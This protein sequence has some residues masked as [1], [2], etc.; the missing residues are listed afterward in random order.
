MFDIK[1]DILKDNP[2][3][4]TKYEKINRVDLMYAV[5]NGCFTAA[6]WIQRRFFIPPP[7]NIDKEEIF[8]N[9]NGKQWIIDN[10]MYTIADVFNFDLDPKFIMRWIEYDNQNKTKI[11]LKRYLKDVN[12]IPPRHTDF[13]IKNFSVQ[14]LP[15]V[16]YKNCSEEDFIKFL[17]ANF[18]C[19][20]VEWI[21]PEWNNVWE[22]IDNQNEFEKILQSQ[23]PKTIK[24]ICYKKH[25]TEDQL[26]TLFLRCNICYKDQ[27]SDGSNE[28]KMMKVFNKI[29]DDNYYDQYKNSIFTTSISRRRKKAGYGYDVFLMKKYG[30]PVNKDLTDCCDTLYLINHCLDNK[31][32]LKTAG[33]LLFF[34][35]CN[36]DDGYEG[37]ELIKDKFKF[38]DKIKFTIVDRDL[39]KT[40]KLL[41]NI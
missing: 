14:I 8:K 40:M 26:R 10:D 20:K 7:N 33:V 27:K 1:K 29:L 17:Q 38:T 2:S 24:N 4:L 18:V 15:E 6:N 9:S 21:K 39:T 31:L 41:S 36:D 25:L 22:H 32:K 23:S 19:N 12:K 37:F 5:E 16:V 13:I 28:Y 30:Y 3:L 35:K 11:E 34:E